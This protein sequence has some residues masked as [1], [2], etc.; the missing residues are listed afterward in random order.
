MSP[1]SYC[2][3]FLFSLQEN[4]DF[5]MPLSYSNMLLTSVSLCIYLADDSIRCNLFGRGVFTGL[6]KTSSWG[7]LSPIIWLLHLNYFIYVCIWGSLYN[8]SFHCFFFSVICNSVYLF[9]T[10][11]LLSPSPFNLAHLVFPS[12]LHYNIFYSPSSRSIG[13]AVA[14]PT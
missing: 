11:Y 2:V 8:S 1:R 7:N 6:Q 12:S 4:Y 3:V 5:Y 9:F 14:M 10:W 13:K